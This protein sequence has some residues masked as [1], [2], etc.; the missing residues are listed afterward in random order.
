[1]KPKNMMPAVPFPY[2]RPLFSFFST[3][4]NANRRNFLENGEASGEMGVKRRARADVH[5]LDSCF[6]IFF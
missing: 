3:I 4:L 2:L 1:M 5:R 6:S